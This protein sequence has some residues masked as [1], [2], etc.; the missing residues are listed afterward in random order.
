VFLG[1]KKQ[2]FEAYLSRLHGYAMAMSRD[3][4]VA[5]DL[6][7]DC[8][9]R[10]LKARKIPRDEAAY[11]AWLFTI[12]RNLWRDHLRSTKRLQLIEPME[13]VQED[14]SPASFEASVVNVLAVRQA[15]ENLSDEH[16]DILAL[17]DIGG[18]SYEEA[19]KMLNI[20]KGTVMSRVSRGRAALAGL[21]SEDN[22]V[23]FQSLQRRKKS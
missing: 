16:R 7:Q 14:M 12:V 1:E 23:E 11:R 8:V 17:V 21:L 22:I 19:A 4:E 5:A 9:L 10:V 13:I 15:F 3:S 20:P 6:V 18:F 2:R